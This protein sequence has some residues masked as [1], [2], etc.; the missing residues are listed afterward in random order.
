MAALSARCRIICGLSD[1][2]AMLSHKKYS[3]LI[4]SWST[5]AAS[6]ENFLKLFR[7]TLPKVEIIHLYDQFGPSTHDP[8][9]NAIIVSSETRSVADQINIQRQINHLPPFHVLEINLIFPFSK[10]STLA[11]ENKISSTQIRTEL[12]LLSQ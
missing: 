9:I 10:Y 6:I 7:P 3:S 11:P 2:S 1:G 8:T 4:Q 12:S 5:R